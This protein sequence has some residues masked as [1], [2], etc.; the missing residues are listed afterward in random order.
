[1]E[2]LIINGVN[3]N[4][5]GIREPDVYGTLNLK[6]MESK[7]NDHAEK[8]GIDLK[9]YQGN[10]E[11]EII[12]KIHKAYEEKIDYII[13]NPAAHTHYSIAIRDALSGVDI[14]TIEVHISNV[15]NREE[16]R[17]KSVIAPVCIGQITGFSYYG[18]LMA[19]DYINMIN[20]TK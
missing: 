20:K 9:T 6:Q 7:I 15:Y 5:L 3:L 14:P 2:V 4:L 19:L 10:T 11:G 18:Y 1:M 12:K 8:L 13:I 17:K 16:F